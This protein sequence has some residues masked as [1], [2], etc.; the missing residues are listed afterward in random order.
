[1]SN[2]S[3]EALK[4]ADIAWRA[5]EILLGHL[6]TEAAQ[7]AFDEAQVSK[8]FAEFHFACWS[9]NAG[10]ERFTAYYGLQLPYCNPSCK[11]TKGRCAA[12]ATGGSESGQGRL[13]TNWNYD[14]RLQRC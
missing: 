7:R 4:L 3:D 10:T 2:P 13:D 9:P 6:A 14:W 1:L 5:G 8:F 11:R 12:P